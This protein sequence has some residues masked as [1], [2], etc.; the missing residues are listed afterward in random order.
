MGKKPALIKTPVEIA[1][2]LLDYDPTNGEFR[3]K[4]PVNNAKK[5]P[6]EIAGGFS[7]NRK[8]W[9]VSLIGQD[10]RAHR[11]AWYMHYGEDPG[12][13]RLVDHING[14]SKDN[15]IDNLRLAT[16]AENSRNRKIGANNTTGVKG[17]YKRGNKYEARIN[18][19]KI[20]MF[21][22]FKEA[23]KARKKAAAKTYGD[24]SNE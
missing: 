5:K 22:T 16:D 8:Y 23:T 2:Q 14:N 20:D 7:S 11:L 6:G 12:P 3:W 13:N 18:D 17:V 9:R 19:K 21:D 4:L 15:R 24:F 10:I 1:R